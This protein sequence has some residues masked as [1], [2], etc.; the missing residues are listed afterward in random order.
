MPWLL[1]LDRT[2]FTFYVVVFVPFVVMAVAMTLGT[3]I[4][5]A[6]APARR[7]RDGA[8][9]ATVIVLAVVI[10]G[11]WFYPVWTG[12]GHPVR[13]LA[14]A[15][16]V[17]VLGVTPPQW[18]TLGMDLVAPAMEFLGSYRESLLRGWSQRDRHRGCG[19]GG[20]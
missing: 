11:W 10:V 15:H 20:R 16:V 13:G 1:Y 14:H 12:A 3:I 7:R 18:H 19:R 4:G 5:P 9:A 17:L 6:D 2:I 8:V